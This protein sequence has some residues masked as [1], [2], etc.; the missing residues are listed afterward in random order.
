MPKGCHYLHWGGGIHYPMLF[1]VFKVTFSLPTTNL[2]T[3]EKDD[4]SLF[5]W[6]NFANNIQMKL[7]GENSN[8]SNF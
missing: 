8:N 2:H 1:Q 7:K 6:G 5:L 3:R 4:V